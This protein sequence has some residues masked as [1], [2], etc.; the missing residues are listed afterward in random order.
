MITSHIDREYQLTTHICKGI[1]SIEDLI[2]AI[3]NLY[4]KEPTPNHLWDFTEA[5]TSKLTGE[6]VRTLA[7]YAKSYAP[8]RIG[9]RTAIVTTNEATFG[10]AR[11]YE[12]FA[13]TTGQKVEIMVFRSLNEAM[14]WLEASKA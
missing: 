12:V 11:M 2:D 6:Q 3:K 5:E 7:S 8:S 9:G 14:R 4:D 13:E 1:V 10:I